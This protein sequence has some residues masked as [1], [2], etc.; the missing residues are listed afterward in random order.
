MKILKLTQ[1]KRDKSR[2]WVE[3]DTGEGFK[4]TE[5]VV[6]DHSLCVG[7]EISDDE[8]EAIR[9][10]SAYSSARA[11]AAHLAG[12][13]LMSKGELVDKLVRAGEDTYAAELAAER[14]AQAGA[15]DDVEYAAQIV[16]HYT[17]R[18]YGSNRIKQELRRRHVP[19]ELWDEALSQ[20]E[21]NG[22]G[23]Y[24]LFSGRIERGGVVDKK[25]LKKA[26]DAMYRRGFGWDEINSAVERY[27]NEK[28]EEI[29]E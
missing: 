19:Q 1:L 15:V 11:R 10:A 2:Y 21:D 8:L 3:T 16:R 7:A 4:T 27:R 9:N 6:L 13:K 25:A 20:A 12:G 17:R 23:A 26:T 14:M 18:G 22:D 28:E 5:D 24:E 29:P